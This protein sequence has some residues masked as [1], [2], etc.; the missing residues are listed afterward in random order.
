[1]DKNESVWE[2]FGENDPYFGV[3][4][5]DEMRDD[6]FVAES[7]RKFFESGRE[8]VERLWAEMQA[9]FGSSPAPRRAL[10][11]GCGVG[12]VA[13]PMAAH[14]ANVVG[15]DISPGM[16]EEARR[17]AGTFGIENA[18]FEKS[19]D[20][21][22]RTAGEFDL[23]HSFVVFQHIYPAKGM[24]I[25]G[26]VIDSLSE[27]GIGIIQFPYAS[28]TATPAQKMRYRLYRDVPGVY[29]LRNL[30]VR[31]RKEPLIPMYPYNLNE[32]MLLLQK[33]G[34]HRCFIKFS[35]HGYEGVVLFFQKTPDKLF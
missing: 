32:V 4:S 15:V 5:T 6:V 25:F 17:N 33:K 22:F 9:N 16:V 10:D 26:E 13:I 30:A 12:R 1:M 19:H 27:N 3:L 7:R 11:F 8:H 23:I 18:S 28:S 2:Y 24:R 29:A 34:C 21:F 20:K 35:D 14:C 31:D